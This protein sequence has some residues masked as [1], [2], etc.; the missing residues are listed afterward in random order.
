MALTLPMV[1]GPVGAGSRGEC[2]TLEVEAPILLPDG[3]VHP[4][5][6]L[7]LCHSKAVSPVSSLHN[8]YVNGHP[9]A[10]LA[11]HKTSSEGGERIV[12]HALFSRT[13]EGRLELI[14]YVLPG[15]GRSVT[16]HLN[17][18]KKPIRRKSR[19]SDFASAPVKESTPETETFV[20][21]ASR[22]PR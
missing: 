22:T 18:G 5:G 10:M 16:Y 1:S 11:S 8:T 17:Q 7:K 20:V 12:P 13:P 4:P 2:I 19:G 14:G 9:V 6:A 15:T 21:M 3:A